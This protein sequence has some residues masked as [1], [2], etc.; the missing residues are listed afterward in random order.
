MGMGT[1]EKHDKDRNVVVYTDNGVV[2]GKARCKESQIGEHIRSLMWAGP[3]RVIIE[4][5]R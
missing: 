5:G 3:V 2:Q 4:L 1:D